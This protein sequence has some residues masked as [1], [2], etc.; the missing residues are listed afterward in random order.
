[1]TSLLWSNR[2]N[3]KDSYST[4]G[5][6][7]N[8]DTMPHTPLTS[9]T[10]PVT[11]KT[12]RSRQ[13]NSPLLLFLLVTLNALILSSSFSPSSST[14]HAAVYEVPV[15]K[16]SGAS[17]AVRPGGN[18]GNFQAKYLGN[19]IVSNAKNLGYTGTIVLGNPPQSFEV[20]FDTGSDMIVVTSDKC[21]GLHC[22]DMPHYTCNSCSKT[23]FSYNITYGDGT[24]G[25]GPIVADR[26]AIGG[27]V[28]NDQQ[29]LDVTQSAL[30]LSAYGPHIAGLVGLMPTSPVLNAIPPLQTI[31]KDKLLDMNV[32]SV[33]LTPSLVARQGGTFLFGGIDNTKFI[34]SLNQVPIATG[35]GTSKGMWYL[36]GDKAYVGD[37]E[38]EGYTPSPWLFDTG[39]SFI[40]VPASFASAFHA[41]VPG[42]N[43]SDTS[44]AYTLPC[45]G[46][47]TF[48]VSFNGVRYT[49]PYEDFV[50]TTDLKATTCVSLIMPLRNYNM[51]ILGDPFLRQVY[52]V[53]DFTPGASRIGLAPVNVTDPG[54][55][56]EGLYG[57][58]VEGGTVLSNN[59]SG[60][61]QQQQ[62]TF[63]W[64]L[65]T[66][67]VVSVTFALTM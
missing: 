26:V 29:I 18:L 33:Y 7:H 39:T 43:Y 36:T 56:T 24:W 65:V 50:G 1:M 44:R 42:A 49:V 12:H 30:D 15:T 48:G 20:V 45:K 51:F 34:G 54:L 28:I 67:A 62:G 5:S 64:T 21:E 27:L 59:A 14:A 38:V 2:N 40:A 19:T 60:S 52:A 22:T 31:Y 3:H 57:N 11:T 37:A 13:R 23:P 8:D 9:T 41:T 61:R 4:T 55:G 25:A 16:G 17:P 10:T 32:F 35:F 46:N 63:V 66:I 6:Y 47:T 53:Y 58:P